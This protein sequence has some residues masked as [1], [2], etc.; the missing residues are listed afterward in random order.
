MYIQGICNA[1]S[2]QMS[3]MSSQ[4]TSDERVDS[5]AVDK[6]II[7]FLG[8]GEELSDKVQLRVHFSCTV[9]QSLGH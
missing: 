8:G 2:F 4:F 3:V 9:Q 1:T 5:E 7:F 6:V